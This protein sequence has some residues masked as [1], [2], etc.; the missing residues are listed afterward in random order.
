MASFKAP[1]YVG[2]AGFCLRGWYLQNFY[3]L[4][5]V[6]T[7]NVIWFW[8]ADSCRF[9]L[10]GLSRFRFVPGSIEWSEQGRMKFINGQL[11]Q[12]KACFV[13]KRFRSILVKI[14]LHD[15]NWTQACWSCI[16]DALP[17]L[18]KVIWMI[19]Y[20]HLLFISP[21]TWCKIIWKLLTDRSFS[22]ISIKNK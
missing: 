21:A 1:G 19:W 2:F 8:A 9:S 4:F 6:S 18:S 15:R 20:R 17:N 3:R 11:G 22:F 5:V 13:S 16:Y 12:D 7:C 10:L 14:L